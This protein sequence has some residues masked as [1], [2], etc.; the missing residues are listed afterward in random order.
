[1]VSR[2][3]D[4]IATDVDGDLVMM[5]MQRGEYFAVTGVGVRVWALIADPIGIEDIVRVICREYVVD[6]AV[7]RAETRAFVDDL[8]EMGLATET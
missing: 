7:C 6:E 5:S 8:I 3:A 1:M 4:L 2:N